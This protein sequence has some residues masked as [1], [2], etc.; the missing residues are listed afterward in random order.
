MKAKFYQQLVTKHD[1]NGNPRRLFITYANSGKWLSVINEGYA[2]IPK[3]LL[4]VVNLP[5]VNVTI[6]EYNS[7]IKSA[8]MENCFIDN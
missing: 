4:G 5:S 7:W 8:K 1:T 2:G 6:S 3:K